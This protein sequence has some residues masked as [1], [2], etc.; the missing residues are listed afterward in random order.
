MSKTVSAQKDAA[1]ATV[2]KLVDVAKLD[3]LY[4][5]LYFQRACTLLDPLL[6]RSSYN[7]LK[8]NLASLAWV[9][10]QLRAAV[11]RGDWK[12]SQE[13]TEHAVR[14]RA[15]A[16]ANAELMKLGEEVY[17]GINE[18]VVDPFSAGFHVFTGSS[19]EKLLESRNEAVQL[20]TALERADPD[21]KDFYARR[22]ADFQALSIK[23]G[24]DQPSEVKSVKGPAELQQ[25][26]LTALESGDLSLLEKVVQK[27]M[28]KPAATETKQQ[29]AGVTPAEALELGD[30][31]NFKFSDATLAAAKEFGLRPIRTK[32]RRHFAHLIPHGWQPSF[33]KNETRQWSQDQISRL[34]YPSE[35]S[36]KGREAIEFYL[37]NPFLTSA[38]TRYRVNLV[39]E[40]LLVE[41]FPEPD[42]KEDLPQTPLLSALG[43]QSRRGLSR[44]DI[45]NALLQNGPAIVEKLSLDPEVFRVVA[46]PPDLYSHL[47]REFGWGEKE[48]WTHFDGYRLLEGGK[49]QA[50]VG[51][52][53]RF[54]GTSDVVSLNSS[55]S[56]D[57]MIA[58]FAVVQRKRMASWH[59]K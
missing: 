20:L 21:K 19:S 50:L 3:V 47:G 28:D 17:E 39:E 59:K 10:R 48:I 29:S 44:T 24:I 26:A 23:G 42:P 5:D 8:E 16:T 37:L 13:L 25:E 7:Y 30:D 53:K 22:R 35:T 36:D 18:V 49:V 38:G 6:N 55:Y 54:G 52:D 9:E 46:I 57:S 51:G 1:I 32:S 14:T 4:R 33:R 31:L 2:R 58:R 43:L 34:T 27:L 56:K 11:E 41:D 15:S 12:R 40:D 45:E